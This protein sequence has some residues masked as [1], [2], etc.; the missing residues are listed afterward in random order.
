MESINSTFKQQG[1]YIKD[2]V[3]GT[4]QSFG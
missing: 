3:L 2:L 1:I 4:S